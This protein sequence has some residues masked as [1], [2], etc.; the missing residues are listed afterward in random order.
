MADGLKLIAASRLPSILASQH[1]RSQLKKFID[2][3]GFLEFIGLIKQGCFESSLLFANCNAIN[4]IKSRDRINN[5]W[6][7]GVTDGNE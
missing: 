3:F 4:T 1:T 2:F 5:I 7:P 6:G